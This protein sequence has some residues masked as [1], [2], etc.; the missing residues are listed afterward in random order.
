[1][2]IQTHQLRKTFFRV[3]AVRDV[4]L[5]VPEGSAYALIGTNGAGK[6]TTIRLL[7]NLLQPSAGTATVLGVDSRRLGP[8][9]LAQIGYVSATQDMPGRLTT[10][11]YLAYLRPFYPTWDQAL[12]RSILQDLRLPLDTRIQYLSHGMRT[13]FALVCA[14]SYRPRLLVLDEPFNGLDALVRDE[15]L[16]GLLRRADAVTMLI[17]SHELAEIEGIVTHVGFLDSG[18]LLLQESMSDLTERVREVRVTL[19]HEAAP[20]EQAPR[21]WL[22][23]RATGNVLSFVDTQFSESD[24]GS[25]VTSKLKGVRHIDAQPVS[26]RSLFT[27]LARAARHTGG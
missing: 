13:K 22:Q 16:E 21:E 24:L 19:D 3:A 25:R 7:M 4:S 11:Q 14:L 26:L 2:I 15:L 6:T 17:S 12:E 9:E 10:G 8:P 1:M 20:P 5:S 18:R 27:T 23:V